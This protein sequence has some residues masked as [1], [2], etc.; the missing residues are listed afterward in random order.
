M[1]QISG[2]ELKD[3]LMQ[4]YN[5]F[6]KL[7]IEQIHIII[8]CKMCMIFPLQIRE[9]KSDVSLKHVYEHSTFVF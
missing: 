7:P 3:R 8:H 1:I 6:G 2:V 5:P 9:H 4:I